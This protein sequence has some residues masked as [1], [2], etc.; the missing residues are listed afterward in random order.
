MPPLGSGGHPERLQRQRGTLNGCHAPRT[1]TALSVR[2]PDS[3]KH[4]SPRV[5][6][7][8][9]RRPDRGRRRLQRDPRCLTRGDSGRS[10]G[11]AL[12]PLLHGQVHHDPA[13]AAGAAKAAQ[14]KGVVDVVGPDHAPAD[15]PPRNALRATDRTPLTL[16]QVQVLRAKLTDAVRGKRAGTHR[17]LP[18]VDL[19]GGCVLHPPGADQPANGLGIVKD[20]QRNCGQPPDSPREGPRVDPRRGRHPTPPK[21]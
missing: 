8:S 5:G 10:L 3:G 13:G 21:R 7:R 20:R 14:P 19:A 11:Q 4:R 6:A 15:H 18:E 9:C 17:G 2:V 12:S 1:A 16:T